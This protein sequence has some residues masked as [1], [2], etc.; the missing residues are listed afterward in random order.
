MP[1]PTGGRASEALSRQSVQ[2]FLTALASGAPTPGGGAAAALSGAMAAR[3]VAMVGRVTAAGDSS[4]E[5]EA[6]AIVAQADELGDRLAR[7]VTED[8][9]AYGSLIDAR[10]SRGGP[11]TVARALARATEVPVRLARA[12]RDVLALCETLA[13]LARRSA[14]SD[15]AVA[16]ALAGA[17]LESGALTARA[18]LAEAMDSEVARKSESELGDLLA[19]GQGVRRRLSA[20]VAARGGR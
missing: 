13:P 14:L 2:E 11:D 5:P 15:L 19:S 8:M 6:S 9:E 10:R 12:S 1:G 7:L 16:A 18:N 17:A 4:V 20:I 3:L